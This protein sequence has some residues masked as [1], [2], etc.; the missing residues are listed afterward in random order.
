MAQPFAV[1]RGIADLAGQPFEDRGVVAAL[2]QFRRQR[3]E[4]GEALVEAA[5]RAVHVEHEDAVGGGFERGAQFG[6]DAFQLH[7]DAALLAA[8]HH[9][10]DEAGVGLPQHQR[11]DPPL[12]LAG[13]AVGAAQQG[14]RVDRAGPAG[15]H[16]LPE[17]QVL[18]GRGEI[19]DRPPDELLPRHPGELLGG[20]VR[21]GDAQVERIDQQHRFEHALDQR[22]ERPV[23]QARPRSRARP[24]SVRRNSTG[25][26]AARGS[27]TP[28]AAVAAA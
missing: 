1:G 2:Q 7:L 13:L 14:V 16:V 17:E 10:D 28:R 6:D 18:R 26:C 24:A 25:A 15:G 5:D 9:R 4:L 8:V 27:R 22:L 20:A 23:S 11:A 21:G 12:D 19:D 3:P